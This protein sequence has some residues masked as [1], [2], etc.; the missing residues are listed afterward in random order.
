MAQQESIIKLSGKVGDLS[1][2]KTKNGYQ[3]RSK[4]GVSADRIAND[5]GYQRTRE[6]NVEFSEVASASKKI[7]DILRIMILLTH[8]PKMASRLTSR[9][10]KMMKADAIN[11][12]GE[13]K[14]LYE[15]FN[16]LK[17]FNFNEAAPL[18][19]T[20]F[21]VAASSIDRVSG[22]VEVV[23]PE[24]RPDVH[25]NKPKGATHFRIT[26]GAAL[27][28]LNDELERGIME[29][30]DSEFLSIKTTTTGFTLSSTLPANALAPIMLVFGVSFYQ[31]VNSV[32]YSLN[33][34]AFNSLSVV[35]IDTV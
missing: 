16:I 28:S 12:R 26:A 20:L 4:G 23:I 10:F 7:R 29:I 5:P 11:V 34:G 1:F 13:R 32:Y 30:K 22:T 3:A 24:I 21:V 14:V 19:N 8:D 9:V 33:N 17:D 27:V 31:E 15:S 35:A 2:F 18:N 25:V 6:N